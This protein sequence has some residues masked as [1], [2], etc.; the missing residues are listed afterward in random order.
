MKKRFFVGLITVVMS[1]TM[2]FSMAVA[3]NYDF[4]VTS[5]GD[6][7]RYRYWGGG[8]Q[9]SYWESSANPNIVY[10]NYSYGYGDA[11]GTA[12]SFNLISSVI[13][14]DDIVSASINLNVLSI[15]TQGRDD[16]GQSSFG[17]ILNSQGTGWKSFDVTKDI[18]GEL[19]TGDQIVDFYIDYTGYS[20]FT[21]GSAEG[22]EPAFLRITTAGTG[23]PVP[24]PATMFLFGSGLL[25]VTGARRKS[26]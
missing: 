15:W 16:V 19:T 5:Q 12:L 26:E 4:F 17:A 21:F 8:Y 25:L 11:S 14:A 2:F 20:G 18:I 6:S 10:H 3:A 23:N 7:V 13:S 1:M 24:V 9:G 22:G